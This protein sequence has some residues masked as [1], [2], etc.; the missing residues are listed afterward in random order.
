[1]AKDF[2]VKVYNDNLLLV[3]SFEVTEDE[4]ARLI[5]LIQ[6]TYFTPAGP[7][8]VPY[9][10]IA[11]N[12]TDGQT[13]YFNLTPWTIVKYYE[14]GSDSTGLNFVRAKIAIEPDN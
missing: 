8:E 1:M 5:D 9:E 11:V 14:K 7:F 10:E 4:C 13:G 6:E 2:Y 12:K 3:N